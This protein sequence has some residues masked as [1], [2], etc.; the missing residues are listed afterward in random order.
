MVIANIILAVS[1]II[2]MT[3]LNANDQIGLSMIELLLADIVCSV[4]STGAFVNYTKKFS[5]TF[6]HGGYIAPPH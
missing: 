6:F 5:E 3:K 2:L 4:A 1:H